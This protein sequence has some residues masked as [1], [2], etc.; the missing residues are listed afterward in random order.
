MVSPPGQPVGD[1]SGPAGLPVVPYQRDFPRHLPR[2]VQDASPPRL[3]DLPPFR[4][5]A[6]RIRP[7]PRMLPA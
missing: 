6:H 5:T 2:G 3:I 4:F 1:A 7:R